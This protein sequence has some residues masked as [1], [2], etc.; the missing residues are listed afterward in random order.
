M[1]ISNKLAESYWLKRTIYAKPFELIVL[2][3]LF[4]QSRKQLQFLSLS[5]YELQNLIIV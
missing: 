5:I 4:N 2:L 3:V 1:Q